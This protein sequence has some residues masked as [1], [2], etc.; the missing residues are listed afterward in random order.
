MIVS[1]WIFSRMRI[2]SDKSCRE[3]RNTHFVFNFFWKSCYL[4]DNVK[5]YGRAGQATD[6]NIT[7]RM[8]FACWITKAT[9]KYLIHT[10]FPRQ[11][12]LCECTSL[13]SYTYIACLVKYD[14]A[15]MITWHVIKWW[16]EFVF[17]IHSFNSFRSLQSIGLP[18]NF[19]IW[20]C[21]LTL[22]WFQF[23]FLLRIICYQYEAHWNFS[24]NFLNLK[25][26]ETTVFVHIQ[27]SVSIK[28]IFVQST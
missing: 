20:S 11:Q 18:W 14:Y 1:C 26:I 16:C 28:V 21:V 22:P 25:S 17:F 4:W 8:C 12:W 6:D 10:A 3:N 13:L 27:H 19:F 23:V 9:D 5:K 24:R 2:V 15:V 7:Q